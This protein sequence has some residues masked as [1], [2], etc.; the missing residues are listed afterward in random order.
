MD[1]ASS[2]DQTNAELGDDENDSEDGD[3]ESWADWIKRVT[4][5]SELHFMRA[6]VRDWLEEQRQRKWQW[7]GHIAR[8]TDSRWGRLLLDWTPNGHRKQG[9]PKTRWS[10]VLVDFF[11]YQ[12]GNDLS[13]KMWKYQALDKDIWQELQIEFQCF[14]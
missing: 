4:K 9:R 7:A 8:R 3:L 1:D 5:E 12:L 6:G 2:S 14:C 10:D 11:R 13:D